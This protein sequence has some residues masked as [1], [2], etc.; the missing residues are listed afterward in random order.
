MTT[1]WLDSAKCLTMNPRVFDLDNQR[2]SDNDK[3]EYAWNLCS[4]CKV[5]S[6]CAED[7]LAQRNQTVVRGGVWLPEFYHPRRKVQRDK[8]KLMAAGIL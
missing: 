6:E 1:K 5:I 4:G 8:L 3:D 2:I 7:A